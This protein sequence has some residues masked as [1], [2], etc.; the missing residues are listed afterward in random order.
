MSSYI[1][2]PFRP[3]GGLCMSRF[4]AARIWISMP[5]DTSDLLLLNPVHEWDHIRGRSDAAFTLVEYGDYQCPDCGSLFGILQTLQQQF[6][7]RLRLVYRHYPLSG[8]HKHAQMAAEAAEAAG[9]QGRFWE[10]HD[11]LFQNQE[12]LERK[13]LLRYAEQLAL[14]LDRVR[15]ELKQE[16]H[17]ERVRQ[18][19]IAGVQNGV[20][21]TPGLFL[22]GVRQP[23]A[24]NPRDLIAL[25]DAAPI[26]GPS[27]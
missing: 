17:L 16:S 13:H 22:N 27:S 26:P 20:N 4:T 1:S 21:G 19:F 7:T 14:D 18:D 12:S 25:L 6:G 9:A 11:L 10:M 15:R 23:G 8:I 5:E 3:T 24:F 2:G